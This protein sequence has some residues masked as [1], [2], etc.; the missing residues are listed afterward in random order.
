MA[1][2]VGGVLDQAPSFRQRLCAKIIAIEITLNRS[3]PP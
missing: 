1:E 3:P 2:G